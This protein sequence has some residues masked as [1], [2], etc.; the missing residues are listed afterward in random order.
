[1]NTNAALF[2][3]MKLWICSLGFSEKLGSFCIYSREVVENLQ[4]VIVPDQYVWLGSNGHVILNLI[5]EVGKSI[6]L[7]VRCFHDFEWTVGVVQFATVLGPF[8]A[9]AYFLLLWL[10][11]CMQTTCALFS[12]MI[13][14]RE[15]YSGDFK[16]T[17]ANLYWKII[18]ARILLR[19]LLDSLSQLSFK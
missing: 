16:T 15:F 7:G 5:V 2:G 19:L 12:C 11:P 3:E 17:H 9:L 8:Q 10:H 4:E 14:T 6:S 1:M 18:N 13:F